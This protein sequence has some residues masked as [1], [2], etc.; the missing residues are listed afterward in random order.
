MF[1]INDEIDFVTLNLARAVD[2][3]GYLIKLFNPQSK[4]ID[5]LIKNRFFQLFWSRSL[6]LL[7]AEHF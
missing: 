6:V 1:N 7:Y 2:E 5:D 4:A 3:T